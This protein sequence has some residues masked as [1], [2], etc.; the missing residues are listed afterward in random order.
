MLQ[1]DFKMT[2]MWS[3]NTIAFI[4]AF[5]YGYRDNCYN[6]M[7]E[8]K[9]SRRFQF[10]VT[11]PNKKL[12]KLEPSFYMKVIVHCNPY[13]Q[14][15]LQTTK[16]RVAARNSIIRRLTRSKGRTNSVVVGTS[17]MAVY[18]TTAEYPC[19]VWQ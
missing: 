1:T 12:V 7:Y 19:L 17:G 15:A 14:R 10:N 9:S 13:I 3:N 11:R 4:E 5:D 18:Y 16:S 8:H 2:Q 6:Q